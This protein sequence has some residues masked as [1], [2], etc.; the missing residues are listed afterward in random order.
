MSMNQCTIASFRTALQFSDQ[1]IAAPKNIRANLATITRS[2][3]FVECEVV[4]DYRPA[5][6]YAPIS[7]EAMDLALVAK[8]SCSLSHG[9]ITHIEIYHNALHIELPHSI[10]SSI[11]VEYLPEEYRPLRELIYLSCRT[12]L[13]TALDELRRRMIGYAFSHNNLHIDNIVVDKNNR[14]YPIRLYYATLGA[15]GDDAAFDALRAEI[16][17]CAMSDNISPSM[18]NED[19]APYDT[20]SPLSTIAPLIE[21]RRRFST[22]QGYGFMDERGRVVIEPQYAF[23]EDFSEGRAIV[24]SVEGREGV[25]DRNGRALVAVAY[26][27][28]IFVE[29]SASIW[30]SL[31][32]RWAE[33]DYNGKQIGEWCDRPPYLFDED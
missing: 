21:N 30:L 15:G 33:Y 14:W 25:I 9:D 20:S 32:G 11:I 8:R 5:I 6:I 18:L 3:H 13:T 12:T 24:R 29:E 26:D 23:V 19:F 27:R 2:R 10:T 1:Y 7:S 22:E 31:D 17:E 16:A 4:I 28:A